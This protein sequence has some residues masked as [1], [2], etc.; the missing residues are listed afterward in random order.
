MVLCLWSQ[1][2]CRSQSAKEFKKMIRFIE[3]DS[4]LSLVSLGPVGKSAM[5]SYL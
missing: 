4:V 1:L 2:N 5:E 3:V